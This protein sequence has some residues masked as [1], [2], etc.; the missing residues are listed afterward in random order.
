MLHLDLSSVPTLRTERLVLDAVADRDAEAIFAMR[1]DPEC[2]RYVPRPLA[3]S[4]S[5]AVA[6]IALIRS[7]QAANACLAWALRLEEEGTAIGILSLLRF[8]PEHHRAEVGYMLAR[9]H[10]GRGL[11]TEAVAAA[12]DHAFTVLGFHSIEGIVDPRNVGSCKVLEHV[13]FVREALFR[14]N[15]LHEGVFLDSAVY[16]LL[17]SWPRRGAA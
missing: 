5:D 16:S 9:E 14:E 7:E 12:V 8:K 10:W 1:S 3:R 17:A 6:H 4:M 11:M 15:F 2:M 13:G